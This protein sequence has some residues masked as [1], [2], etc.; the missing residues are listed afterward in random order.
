MGINKNGKNART[1]NTTTEETTNSFTA[2]TTNPRSKS[3]QQKKTKEAKSLFESIG[4]NERDDP[5]NQTWN[6]FTESLTDSVYV[7]YRE[8][9][10]QYN[11]KLQDIT[12]NNQM[13][14]F[15]TFLQKN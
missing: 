10:D 12:T 14:E 7:L 15:V 8:K 4:I 13:K 1:T 6:K 11:E 5:S 9:F 3:Y 2:A